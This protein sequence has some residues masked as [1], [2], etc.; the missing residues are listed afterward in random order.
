[1]G[2]EGGSPRGQF[3][4][5][6]KFT[7]II[8]IKNKHAEKFV[9]RSKS[10]KIAVKVFIVRAKTEEID[11]KKKNAGNDDTHHPPE[12]HQEKLN[13]GVHRVRPI[14]VHQLTANST[15]INTLRNTVK[16]P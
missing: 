6:K 7:R 3:P 14:N 9:V 4:I 12:H 5:K 8:N 2:L 13:Q 1:M 16:E 15:L 10:K 11:V